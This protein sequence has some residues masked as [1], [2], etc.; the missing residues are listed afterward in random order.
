MQDSFQ[1]SVMVEASFPEQSQA[2]HLVL[3][4][5]QIFDRS[6]FFNFDIRSK[7]MFEG[8]DAHL[9][10]LSGP[11]TRQLRPNSFIHTIFIDNHTWITILLGTQHAFRNDRGDLP[12]LPAGELHLQFHM[13][14]SVR[15]QSLCLLV[16]LSC[17]CMR[18]LPEFF[19]A[20]CVIG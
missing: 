7:F 14:C 19:H 6:A 17:F 16:R 3:T 20:T 11:V 18:C 4:L 12:P 9:S 2:E 8:D 13:V 10:T 15:R 1:T 5:R